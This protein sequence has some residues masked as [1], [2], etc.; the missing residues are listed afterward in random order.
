MNCILVL[1]PLSALYLCAHTLS[2][3]T[4][5]PR[6]RSQKVGA[7]S[8]IFLSQGLA[9]GSMVGLGLPRLLVP[10]EPQK[11]PQLQAWLP[12]AELCFSAGQ[13]HREKS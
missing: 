2:S 8:L 9:L 5:L 10:P 6:E 4:G 3:H 1:G 11:L 7:L 13:L 12:Q